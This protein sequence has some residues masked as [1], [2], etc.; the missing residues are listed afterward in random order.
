M[1]SP[2]PQVRRCQR[3]IRMV[4]ELHRLGYQRARFMPYEYPIAFRIHVG[5]ASRFS[6]ENGAYT[7]EEDHETT[8]SSASSTSYFGWT[9]ADQ[10]SAR[11]L[12][13][14]FVQRFPRVAAECEGRDWAYAG[15]LLELTGLLERRPSRLPFTLAEHFEPGPLSLKALPLRVYGDLVG[16][17]D[18]GDLSFP[19]PPPGHAVRQG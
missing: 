4:S 10:D 19:L 15:W 12:A 7:A 2:D 5:A 14:K 16:D 9:D 13:E 11:E 8:Y 3:I 18:G 1:R 6:V 17:D